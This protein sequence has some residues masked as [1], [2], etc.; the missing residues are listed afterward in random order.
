MSRISYTKHIELSAEEM[1]NLAAWDKI[2]VR[3][4]KEEDFKQRLIDEP[5]AALAEMGFAVPKGTNY[6]VVENTPERKHIVLPAPPGGDVTVREVE[7]SPLH[8][9]DA[10]F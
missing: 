2:V 10:G 6:V 8:D 1:A 3:A 7:R 9:Y 4:W 5:N